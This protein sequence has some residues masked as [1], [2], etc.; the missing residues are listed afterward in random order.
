MGF[1]LAISP[2]ALSPGASFTLAVSNISISGLRS[3]F[4]I[5]LGTGVGIYIHGLLVGVGISGWIAN[6]SI[7]MSVLQVFG[8]LFLGY[9]GI[10]LLLNGVVSFK[11]KA[12]LSSKLAGFKEA[13]LLNLFNAKA[14]I[15]YLTVVP[16]FA[17]TELV[18]YFILSSL[19]VAVMAVWILFSGIL[20]LVAKAKLKLN[21][22][23]GIVNTIGGAF[24][25]VV[26][27][28]SAFKLYN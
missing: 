27:F 5:I 23:N 18:N 1:L 15:L 10:R 25:V 13:L 8:V 28:S 2:I 16:I 21:I 24:L 9:L 22:M 14:I 20:I 7:A 17:G 12:E 3:A 11:N 6:S 4:S 26:A 19:H